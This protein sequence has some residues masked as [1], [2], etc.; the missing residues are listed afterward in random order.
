MNMFITVGT[1]IQCEIYNSCIDAGQWK[2]E[3]GADRLVSSYS[4]KIRIGSDRYRSMY[5]YSIARS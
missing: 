3:D 5:A 4:I 2:L 1:D